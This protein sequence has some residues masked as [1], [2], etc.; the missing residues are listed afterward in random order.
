MIH[1]GPFVRRGAEAPIDAAQSDP[2]T[3]MDSTD[4][5]AWPWGS[6]RAVREDP[7]V[8][9]IITYAFDPFTM[10]KPQLYQF[11]RDNKEAL[12]YYSQVRL[13][14][15]PLGA[16]EVPMGGYRRTLVQRIFWL[17]KAK[18]EFEFKFVGK[19]RNLAPIAVGYCKQTHIPNVVPGQIGKLGWVCA[20]TRLHGMDMRRSQ[21]KN[22]FSGPLFE[23]IA[24]GC[25]MG[26]FRDFPKMRNYHPELATASSAADSLHGS[27][28]ELWMR[29]EPGDLNPMIKIS[30]NFKPVRV[31]GFADGDAL[32]ITSKHEGRPVGVVYPLARNV[33]ALADGTMVSRVVIGQRA[34][35]YKDHP[36]T[37]GV[38]RYEAA[39]F[40]DDHD[41]GNTP[42]ATIESTPV[43]HEDANKTLH[44]AGYMTK[45]LLG[46]T[47]YT[48]AP[49][50][51]VAT[52]VTT[53]HV[54]LATTDDGI[55]AWDQHLIGAIEV[56]MYNLKTGNMNGVAVM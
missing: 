26:M 15:E 18:G 37:T 11:E 5:G 45:P 32:E 33:N 48:P 39:I 50:G 36:G 21:D 2:V 16:V 42:V 29:A 38:T 1:N 7:V 20:V 17:K 10:S 54:T 43:A 28:A 30:D 19:N 44:V 55:A 40:S 35:T 46:S 52:E 9:R 31:Q 27:G 51:A 14:G 4:T 25:A 23:A 24:T 56:A 49:G 13:N 12:R 47:W 3:R 34:V 6:K 53:A 8:P 41:N 22:L